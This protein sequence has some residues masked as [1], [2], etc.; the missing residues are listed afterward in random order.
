[1]VFHWPL[2]RF[3]IAA[4]LIGVAGST[5]SIGLLIKAQYRVIQKPYCQEALQLLQNN[6]IAMEL[7]GRPIEIK[8]PDV[9]D[10]NQI[11]GTLRTD[12][13]VPF[14]G[15]NKSGL[16]HIEADRKF[17]EQD[18]SVKRLEIRFNDIPEKLLIAYKRNED[19]QNIDLY[20]KKDK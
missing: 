15:S 10:K 11:F 19:N 13:N 17:A 9:I 12:I 20:E 1:M 2:R 8:R 18:W 3:V 6:S 16:L 5:I 7:I 14:V 4:S